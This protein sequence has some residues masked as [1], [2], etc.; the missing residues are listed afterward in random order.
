[1]DDST[2]GGANQAAFMSA[3]VT[4]HFVLQS[5]ASTTVSEA[6]G[7][8]SLYLSAVSSSLVAMGFAAQAHGAFLPFAGAV[9]PALLVMGIFT[10]VRLVDTGV[11][12]LRYLAGIAHIRAY[13][14]TLTPAAASYFTPWGE[15]VPATDE[16]GQALAALSRRRGV[17][18]SVGT[19]A[20]LISAINSLVAGAGTA[21]ALDRLLGGDRLAVAVPV[22]V[23][24][25]IAAQLAFY[26]YQHR[27]YVLSLGA[28]AGT[29]GGPPAGA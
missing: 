14:R 9:I 26:G 22:G 19:T 25:A 4:E 8:A 3:L 24:V 21:L 18:T 16:A 20:S 27:R 28:A 2:D 29:S 17:I 15:G 11:Q 1:M 7:R 10:I 6:S 13:Y 12:N 5:A 23:A